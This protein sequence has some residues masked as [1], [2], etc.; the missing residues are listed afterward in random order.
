MDPNAA[1]GPP[2]GV[3]DPCCSGLLS[4]GT[5]GSVTVEF[6]D[7]SIINGPGPD[8]RI[9]G[10]PD[11]DE[12]VQVKVSADGT[13]WKDFGIVQ[14]IATLDLQAV[15]LEFAKYVR[16]IDDAI[17]EAGGINNSAELDTIEALHSGPPQ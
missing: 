4:L 16:V 5:G 3:S 1:L 8:L 17:P 7:N 11:N 15:G 6:T 13:D 12:R 9:I 10:D 14:E 2:D